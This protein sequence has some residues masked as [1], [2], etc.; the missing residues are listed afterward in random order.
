M[1]GR[2]NF[3][4]YDRRLTPY[5]HLRRDAGP[6]LG[7]RVRQIP[8]RQTDRERR[9]TAR[10]DPQARPKAEWGLTLSRARELDKKKGSLMNKFIL[11]A[12]LIAASGTGIGSGRLVPTVAAAVG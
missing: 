6:C 3:L 10:T 9:T 11:S 12:M 4:Q 2:V 1:I 7:T 5:Y 8:V